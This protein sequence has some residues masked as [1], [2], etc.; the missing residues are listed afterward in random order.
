MNW[1]HRIFR[2][3]LYDDLGEELRQH[4]EEKAEQL[5]RTENL[6]RAKAEQAARRAF[7]NVT[8]MEQR[9]RETWQWPAMESIAADISFALRQIRR[10]P[11][12]SVAV[13]LLLALGIGATTAVFSLVDAILLKPVPYPEPNSVVIPWNIPPAGVSIGGFDKFPWSPIHFHAFEQ[14]TRTFRWLGAFQGANFNLTDA[15]DPAMLEG[16]QVSWGFFPTMGISPALGRTFT[17]EEDTPGKEREVVLGDA[18]WRS[19]FHADPTILNRVIHLDGAAYMVVGIMPRGFDFPRANEM[20]GDFTFASKTQLWVPIALPAVT[21]RFTSSELAIVARLQPGLSVAQAQNAMDLFAQRMDREHPEMKGWSQSLV[22]PLQRQVAG[23]TGR[24]L[25]L[26]LS[27]VG[28]VLLIVC[29]N[30]A[31][32]LLTRSIAREREFTLRAA[33]GAGPGRVLRQVLTES[34]LLAVAG[35]SGAAAVAAAGISLVKAFGPPNLPRLQEAGADP[36]VFAFTCVITLLTGVLFGLAPALGAGRVNLAG[37]LR[38]GGQKSGAGTSHPRLRGALVVSQIA[39][40][41]ALVMASGLLVRS[42]YQLL[43]SDSGF[44]ADHVLTFELS[45]PGTRYSERAAIARFYQKALPRLRAIPG[46]EYAGLTESVPLNGATESGVARIVG[47][48]L[49]KG[50]RPPIVDYTIISPGLFSALGTPLVQG[51]DVLDSDVLSAPPVTVINRA[52]AQHYWP[53]EDPIGKQILV[54]SQRVPATII[55][56]VADMKHSSLREV[57]GPGMFEPYTQE[58]W[59]SMALMH[60]VLRTKADPVTA[61]GAAREIIR[62]LDAGIPLA[63]VATLTAITHRS[64]AANRFSML[65]V[66]FFGALALV[67]AAV[68][69]YGIIAYSAS[70]RTREIAIR[71]ALGA[72]RGNVFG[73]VLGQGL[74]LAALGILFGVLTALLVGRV[75]AGWLYGVSA[76]DPLTLACVAL[77]ITMVALAASFLPARRAASTAP[78]EALRGD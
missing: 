47:R 52:M 76:S 71:I 17:R 31:G 2:R 39:M 51:R 49:G 9:S 69:I 74:R 22:T 32:L 48:P 33:L 29:F 21:P 75:L 12:F 26:I 65:V 19:R 8:L 78:M 72:Q 37:S 38:E 5:M 73:M 67:L 3:R 64:M 10:S 54:P 25:L 27:A 77:L 4:I 40:A 53:N 41:L 6:P 23:D 35:G 13:I 28:V 50:E 7:G 66:G 44:H 57:P 20:P 59:P 56:V 43:A 68:G 36:R 58:V 42:F 14:E 70:Q 46:V 18:L 55:G 15:G 30:V 1:F 62:D 16:A 11:G 34:L 63:D 45:L 60:V 24:P 61:I